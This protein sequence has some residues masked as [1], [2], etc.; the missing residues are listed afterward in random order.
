[1][2]IGLFSVILTS[3]AAVGD[4]FTATVSNVEMTFQVISDTEVQV[5]DG[6][7]CMSVYT[8]GIISIPST[9]YSDKHRK[10]FTVPDDV[11]V[12][13]PAAF[14]SSKLVSLTL[15]DGLT[16]IKG[17]AFSFC[18]K[19]TSITIPAGVTSLTSSCFTHCTSLK[20]VTLFNGD[21]ASAYHPSLFSDI[22]PDATLRVPQEY[23]SLY[24]YAPWQ[25]WFDNIEVY[26]MPYPLWVN[27]QQVKQSMLSSLPV[28][29]GSASYDPATKT[30][31]LNDAVMNSKGAGDSFILCASAF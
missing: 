17:G 3:E 21:I 30:L 19:L 31:T 18:E 16:T 13:A 14:S 26:D 25:E 10:Y 23:L 1:M 5:G 20:T 15:P 6:H 12:L 29:S 8:S 22:A 2:L 4:T 9:V 7:Y 24:Q 11:T 27:G 28:N